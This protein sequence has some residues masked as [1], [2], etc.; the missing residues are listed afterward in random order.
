[1]N[2]RK[3]PH[4]GGR[5]LD[6]RR[7]DGDIV[8]AFR[9]GEQRVRR[10][11]FEDHARPDMCDVAGGIE[12]AARCEV[13]P[14]EQQRL[15]GEFGNLQLPPACQA[16]P[17]RNRSKHVNGGQQSAVIAVVGGRNDREVNV[18]ALQP[19]RN[20]STAVLDQLDDDGGVLASE[21]GEEIGQ[22]RLYMLG[23]AADPQR[24]GLARSQRARTLAERFG[25]LQETA[26]AP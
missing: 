10:G 14:Q 3:G 8:P 1:M 2:E 19:I 15:I 20:A 17:R 26:T 9:Q 12:P 24:A 25:V 21:R 23:A 6:I 4:A 5:D 22:H 16:M 7:H 13:P 18:A 11:T